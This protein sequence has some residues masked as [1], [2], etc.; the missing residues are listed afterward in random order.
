MAM[1]RALHTISLA[2]YG[3]LNDYTPEVGDFVVWS[4]WWTHWLGVVS[5]FNPATDEL[6]I[7]FATVPF[8][9]FTMPESERAKETRKIK[10]SDIKNAFKGA[11][12]IQQYGKT[13]SPVW[14]V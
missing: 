9:L 14:Y 7:I 12:A 13:N 10:L 6:S 2:Q 1:A 4:G 8:N 3:N 11:W 5:H